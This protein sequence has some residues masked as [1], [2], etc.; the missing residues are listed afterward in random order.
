M[1]WN[2]PTEKNLANGAL[3]RKPWDVGN[4][5]WAGARLKQSD[6]YEPILGIIFLRFAVMH[7]SARRAVLEKTEASSRR[8]SK[9]DTPTAYQ[10]EGVL[11][12]ASGARFG[13]QLRL[14]EGADIGEA[15]NEVMKT[16]ERDNPQMTGVLP[17]GYR[18]SIPVCSASCCCQCC[19]RKPPNVIYGTFSN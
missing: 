4:Q 14:P 7:L 5:L 1:L 3:E 11:F 17:K 13:D 9:A 19:V 10:A 16:I 2:A 18:S 8:E 6:Y 15:L 12:L